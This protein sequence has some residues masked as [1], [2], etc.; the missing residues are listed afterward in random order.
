MS[1]STCSAASQR[2]P[3]R[4]GTFDDLSFPRFC[5]CTRQVA[6]LDQLTFPFLL[7]LPVPATAASWLLRTVKTATVIKIPV[8]YEISFESPPQNV[9][10]PAVIIAV[11]G[12]A[13]NSLPR[14]AIPEG[15]TLVEPIEAR[16]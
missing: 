2:R 11:S 12:T 6:Q 9:Q 4:I 13:D 16:I 14:R 15:R 3:S 7:S 8:H 5:R 1:H 10:Q